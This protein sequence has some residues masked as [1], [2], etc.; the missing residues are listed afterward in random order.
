MQQRSGSL[1]LVTIRGVPVF[2]HWSVPIAGLL[3]S[4]F[5]GFQPLESIYY[6]VAF[7]LLI[8]VHELGHFSAA[9]FF[10]LKVFAI[11]ISGA[12]GKC[13]IQA[14]FPPN[15]AL[16]SIDGFAPTGFS[17]GIE[18]FNDNTT[19]MQFVADVLSDTFTLRGSRQY[20]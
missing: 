10:G 9:R 15:T 16:L 5:A 20:A 3:L 1:R 18:V 2:I 11:D 19:P 17:T 4:I 14:V 8:A 12:G 6:C 13:W 7:V